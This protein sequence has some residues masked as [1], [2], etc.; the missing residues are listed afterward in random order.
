[1]VQGAEMAE[2]MLVSW[3]N[4]GYVNESSRALSKGSTAIK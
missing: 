2:P 1:M 4:E 3:V